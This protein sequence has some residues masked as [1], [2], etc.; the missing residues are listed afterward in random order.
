MPT[1]GSIRPVECKYRFDK[2]SGAWDYEI[3][4]PKIDM[5]LVMSFEEASAIYDYAFA[6]DVTVQISWFR[7]A[8]N[9]NKIAADTMLK[10]LN[11]PPH[12]TCGA[13][14]ERG[15]RVIPVPTKYTIE[16]VVD[17]SWNP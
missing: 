6:N 3:L 17:R 14:G 8:A 1:T 4:E 11:T 10:I 16:Q 12:Y 9:R 2:E 15:S 5:T 7:N 13:T